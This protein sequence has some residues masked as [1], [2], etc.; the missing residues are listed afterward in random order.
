MRL[1]E[2]TPP[3]LTNSTSNRNGRPL[4]D[5][6]AETEDCAEYQ[7][8]GLGG[9][10]SHSPVCHSPPF[11]LGGRNFFG[12]AVN[13]PNL[14]SNPTMSRRV[15]HKNLTSPIVILRSSSDYHRPSAPPRSIPRSKVRKNESAIDLFGYPASPQT[16]KAFRAKLKTL[17]RFYF[18]DVQLPWTKESDSFRF[19]I[20]ALLE[21][22]PQ[23][24]WDDGVVSKAVSSIL[25]RRRHEY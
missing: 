23:A 8:Q 11:R 21:Q 13:I 3:N 5:H 17:A 19:F 18:R 1:G 10:L 12:N 9:N 2:N 6:D 24:S 20:E 4:V 7:V 22:F 25:R 16:G 15:V 14:P